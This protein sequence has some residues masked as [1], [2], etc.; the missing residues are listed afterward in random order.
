MS[1]LEK[2]TIRSID[3]RSSSEKQITRLE[4]VC[5][6]NERITEDIVRNHFKNDSLFE[7]I[8][9]EEQRTKNER[10]KELLKNAS[11]KGSGNSGYPEF[12]I[13]FPT[14]MNSVIVI[15]CKSE[16]KYHK[17]KPDQSRDPEKYAVDGALHYSNF[18]KTEFNVI[19]I[20]VSGQDKNNL[21]VSNF[22]IK[23]N[24]TDKEL[25]DTKL[26]SIYDYLSLIENEKYVE[27]LKHENILVT[28]SRLNEK[29]Y[30]YSVPENERATI[31]SGILIALQSEVFRKSYQTYQEPAHLVDDLLVHVERILEKN[32]MGDK[33]PALMDQYN[34]IKKSS[35]LTTDK[36]VRNVET[37][38]E[39][40]NTLLRDLIYDI[41]TKIFP[42]TMYKNAG[43]DILGQFYSEFIR[44]ANGDKKLGLVLTPLH[45]RELFVDLVDLQKDD[46]LYDNCCGT[47]GFLINGMKK[48]MQLA[49]SD[50]TKIKE[51]K[52]NQI[53]GIEERPDMFTYACS[54]MMM[55][56]DGKSNIFR[57]DS[58]SETSK[59]IIKK[60]KPTVGFLNPPYSTGVSELEFVHSN[61]DCLE[62]KGSRCVAIVPL[63]SILDDSGK[64]YEW[65]KKLL[66]KHTL[67]AVFS[68]PVEVFSPIV[69]IVTAIVVFKAHTPHTDDYETYFGYWRDDGFVK[70]KKVGRIDKDGKWESI[71]ENW[72]YNFKN[73]KEVE[74][75]SL[76]K[77]V[78]AKDE[79]CAEAY[80]ET[81]YSKIT[82]ED[83]LKSVKEY[84]IHKIR[85]M[86]F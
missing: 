64:N 83:Y 52:N 37:G 22:I 19:A 47:A 77:H 9:F 24:G 82:K 65:K 50:S 3:D 80:M 72:L 31:V 81:D 78:T 62:S 79:W 70:R 16:E 53:L 63:N 61:L 71:K 12:I 28:A 18:L 44:Y 26:L 15:E 42:L 46:I 54:N 43:Y 7:S 41:D 5:I 69:G 76:M 39:E 1:K 59:K 11:K 27:K 55:R 21:S 60:Q 45:I 30:N 13:T 85:T 33:I 73:K 49:G 40:T 23:K 6:M 14:S 2:L 84:V 25:S 36:T 68:M 17:S 35:K 10:I 51:I 86:N 56:G 67:V 20:A 74:G 66:E 29:L 32:E 57:G 58:L 8:K 48:L 4:A 75:Q 34:T 38:I